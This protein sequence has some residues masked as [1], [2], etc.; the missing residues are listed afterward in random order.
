MYYIYIYLYKELERE[1][2]KPCTYII[3]FTALDK[4]IRL[5]PEL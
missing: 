1:I 5:E 2:E 4:T 3:L